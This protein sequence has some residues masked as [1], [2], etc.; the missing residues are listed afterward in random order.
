MIFF[1]HKFKE[2]WQ[3]FFDSRFK[4]PFSMPN[5]AV[6]FGDGS[7]HAFVFIKQI[8]QVYPED[9]LSIH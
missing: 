1:R 2:G 6:G 7:E 4:N 3:G 5:I 8:T 9:Y